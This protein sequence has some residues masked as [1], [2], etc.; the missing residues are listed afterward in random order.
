MTRGGWRWGEGRED[1]HTQPT[2]HSY[3]WI[4][5]AVIGGLW[6]LAA[7][8]SILSA[9]KFISS[10]KQNH[11]EVKDRAI[12]LWRKLCLVHPESN[13]GPRAPDAAPQQGSCSRLEPLLGTE[14]GPQ[15]SHV[16]AP[17]PSRLYLE[18]GLQEVSRLS[19]VMGVGP[20]SSR[21]GVP[22]RRR[23]TLSPPPPGPLCTQRRGHVRTQPA[24]GPCKPE[25]RAHQKP[26]L[27]TLVL[28]VQ[29]DSL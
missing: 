26:P 22:V 14:L 9:L 18:L 23:E 2:P 17:P 13:P 21:T 27:R 4:I 28:D 5:A 16:V 12:L 24:G 3:C 19:E 8:L 20:R 15:N 1:G 7:G 6:A 25:G 29:S 11:D 10:S